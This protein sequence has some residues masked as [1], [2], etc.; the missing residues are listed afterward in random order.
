M[1]KIIF[2][3][4]A[5]FGLSISPALAG[6]YCN[7]EGS[8]G[9]GIQDTKVGG[10]L[11]DLAQKGGIAG[12]GLNCGVENQGFDVGALARYNLMNVRGGGVASVTADG[13]W[14]AAAK[15]GWNLNS[16]LKLFGVAGY[17]GQNL[18]VKSIPISFKDPHGP[19][20]GGGV[21][22]QVSGPWWAGL[23]YDWYNFDSQSTLG[24]IEPDLH[25][26]RAKF[27]YRF[28]GERSALFTNED[29]NASQ[30][31]DPKLRGKC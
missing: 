2:A 8:A 28:G 24:G 30:G 17:A 15:I 4:L 27:I 21:E 22:F 20:L 23:E 1:R 26:V 11:L 9:L 18:D 6:G 31:C 13:L 12:F 25:V 14:E 5:V 16:K 29:D 7:V 10:G 3:A 19:M